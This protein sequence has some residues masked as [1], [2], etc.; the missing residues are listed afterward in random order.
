MS[1]T[2]DKAGVT[3]WDNTWSKSKLNRMADPDNPSRGYLPDRVFHGIFRPYLETVNATEKRLIEIGCGN[4]GWLPYFYRRFGIRVT[5]IDYADQG[6]EMSKAIFERERV[7]GEVIKGDLF[8]PPSELRASHDYV[9]SFGVVEHFEDT[10]DCLRAMAR[11]LKPGGTMITIIPNMNGVIG[12]TQKYLN[13]PIYD[14]H[15]PLDHDDLCRAHR[16]AGLRV[17]ECRY[18]I[19]YHF[20]VPNLNKLNPDILG[21]RIKAWILRKLRK[22]QSSLWKRCETKN[23]F[24]HPGKRSAG[25]VICIARAPG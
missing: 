2:A 8:D 13:R 7:P 23:W 20:G 24:Q 16:N 21:T 10:A 12:M 4:S 9:F 1:K 18:V 19:P 22:L 6:C 17:E 25:Y 3:Y 15:V 5:G 14:I 11:F